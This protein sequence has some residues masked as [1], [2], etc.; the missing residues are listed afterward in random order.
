[1]KEGAGAGLKTATRLGTQAT[2]QASPLANKLLSCAGVAL[3]ALRGGL[4][5]AD[6]R[7]RVEGEVSGDQKAG[8]EAFECFYFWT[9]AFL[10]PCLSP[11]NATRAQRV[12]VPVCARPR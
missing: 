10:C 5:V 9:V 1:M 6:Q 2:K 3:R 11:C 4:V 12:G 8:L 7:V